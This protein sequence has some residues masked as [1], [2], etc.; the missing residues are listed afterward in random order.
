[1]EG[2]IACNLNLCI[3]GFHI[4]CDNWTP[5]LDERLVCEQQVGNSHDKYAVS[6]VQDGAVI[7]HLL[8]KD[9]LSLFLLIGQEGRVTATVSGQRQPSYDLPQGGM[10]TP[11]SLT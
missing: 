10:E 8:K 3:R 4:H 1:M 7:G 5:T 2:D 9:F 6:G 11:C